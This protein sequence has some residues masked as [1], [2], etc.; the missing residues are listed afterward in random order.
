MVVRRVVRGEA[1]LPRRAQQHLP[2]LL[3]THQLHNAASLRTAS[4]SISASAHALRVAVH[5]DPNAARRELAATVA[6][7]SLDDP[8]SFEGLA[9][10]CEHV[11]IACD[12]ANLAGFVGSRMGEVNAFTGE[13]TTTSYAQFEPRAGTDLAAAAIR[14]V[15]LFSRAADPRVPARGAASCASRAPSPASVSPGCASLT[16]SSLPSSS[17]AP[18]F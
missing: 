17:A 13:R 4:R 10:L 12:P 1:S 14:F 5:S 6:C 11:T 16:S 18:P 15:S 9:H 2:R 3:G 7:G 8:A